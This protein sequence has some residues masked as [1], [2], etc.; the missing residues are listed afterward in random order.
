V[1]Q[2]VRLQAKHAQIK[3]AGGTLIAISADS[4]EQTQALL[5][6][7]R[8]KGTPLEFPVVTDPDRAA[9]KALGFYDKAHDIALPAIVIL[10]RLGKVRWTYAGESVFDRPQEADLIKTLKGLSAK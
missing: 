7:L 1:K 9:C 5:A 3:A 10:D 4:P 2:L 6:K 8:T